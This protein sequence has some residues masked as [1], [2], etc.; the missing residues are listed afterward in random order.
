MKTKIGVSIGLLG[1]AVYFLGLV[2]GYVPI[3]V[4]AGY[5][6][7]FESDNWLK[8]SAIKAV[9][10]CLFFSIV[11]VVV[12]LIPNA[13]TLVDNLFRI[14]NGYFTFDFVQKIISLINT[15]ILIMEKIVLLALGFNALNQK[16]FN[17]G[18]VDRLIAKHTTFNESATTNKTKSCPTCGAEITTDSTFCGSC[19]NK[20]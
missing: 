17:F 20:I 6:L 7:L 5:I 11:S 19:G 12:G 1:A 10:V 16:T 9:V 2:G 3:I 14:F 13:I 15:M 18:I 8:V 4:L